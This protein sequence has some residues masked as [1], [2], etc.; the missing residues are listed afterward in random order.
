MKILIFIILVILIISCKDDNLDSPKINHF[1][2][3]WI[4]D[5]DLYRIE[6]DKIFCTFD[7]IRI[8]NHINQSF[9]FRPHSLGFEIY[10]LVIFSDVDNQNFLY[11]GLEDGSLEFN[12]NNDDFVQEYIH[13]FGGFYPFTHFFYIKGEFK[14]RTNGTQKDSLNFSIF[15]G[16][17]ERFLYKGIGIKK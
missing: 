1:Q 12:F 16:G 8:K 5:V 6:T 2:G 7:T 15:I 10:K 13:L 3:D 11:K 9:T 17:E 4:V 14:I